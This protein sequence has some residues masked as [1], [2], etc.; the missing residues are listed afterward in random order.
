MAAR[1]ITSALCGAAALA[2]TLLTQ[3]GSRWGGFHPSLLLNVANTDAIAGHIRTLDPAFRFTTT[4]DHY[5]GVYFW[6]MAQDP[7]ALGQAHGLIDLAAYR[8]GHPLY[9]WVA[10]LLSLGH[11]PAL[12]WIF[13]M[14]SLLSMAGAAVVLSRLALRLGASPWWGLIVTM[15]PGLLFSASTALTEPAQVAV[16]GLLVLR[17]LDDRAHP[18]GL[19]LLVAAMCLLKEPLLLVVV[20]LG[21]HLLGSMVRQRRLLWGRCLA[22]LAGPIALG[23]WLLVIRGRFS[24]EQQEY[25]VGNFGLP[26][27]GWFETFDFA[28]RLRHGAFAESQIGSTAVP[29]L[30][31]I[32]ALLIAA[33]VIGLC[34]RDALG[35]VVVCQSVLI[36]CLGWRTLLYP[37]EMFRIPS[38]AVAFAALLVAIQ[39]STPRS[40][41]PTAA[42]ASTT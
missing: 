32:A 9:S 11:A 5:D 33:S 8:Y 21:L 15:S 39:L 36:A 1:W 35:L 10:G 37:H 28:S 41:A 6:A 2:V 7:F 40:A 30:M 14:L 25:D 34:R 17:W 13:W 12:P 42:S 31:A 26:I 19:G 27:V 16:V 38:V 4:S 23:L 29:G 24:A 22:L 20:G 18:V 3:L